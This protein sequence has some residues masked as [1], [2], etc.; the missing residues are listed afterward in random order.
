MISLYQ[1]SKVIAIKKEHKIALNKQTN[2]NNSLTIKSSD[3]RLLFLPSNKF[4]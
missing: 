2:Q 3:L 4:S 1:T